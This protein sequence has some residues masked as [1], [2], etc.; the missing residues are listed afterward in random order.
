[1]REVAPDEN[2][3]YSADQGVYGLILVESIMQ[4][5]RIFDIRQSERKTKE[6]SHHKLPW[7]GHPQAQHGRSEHTTKS[8]ASCGESTERSGWDV[9]MLS[10]QHMPASKSEPERQ[11]DCCQNPV[12]VFD[13]VH[14]MKRKENK[15]GWRVPG[16]SRKVP[17][18]Y[19]SDRRAHSR[20]QQRKK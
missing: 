20:G 8:G 9:P 12:L 18:H 1:L 10:E 3:R 14:N 5:W 17:R 16:E 2:A 13:G 19:S 15:M 11:A 6:S 4:V 7:A